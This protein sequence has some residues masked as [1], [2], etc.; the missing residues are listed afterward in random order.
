MQPSEFEFYDP[1]S[2]MYTSPRVVPPATIE[3]S[4]VTDA[5]VSQVRSGDMH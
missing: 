5:I 4:K 2:P 3:N 1:Q